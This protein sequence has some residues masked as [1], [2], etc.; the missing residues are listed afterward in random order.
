MG[1]EYEGK[2]DSMKVYVFNKEDIE[3]YVSPEDREGVGWIK[4]CIATEID[5]PDGCQLAVVDTNH[6][7]GF[8]EEADYC[9]VVQVVEVK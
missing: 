9:R 5:I 4:D 1:V 6:G 2:E 3:G 8:Q 7:I